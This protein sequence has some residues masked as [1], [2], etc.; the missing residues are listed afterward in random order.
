MAKRIVNGKR[1]E[2]LARWVMHEVTSLA[3][4]G[5]YG[6]LEIKFED[7]CPVHMRKS[8]SLIPPEDLTRENPKK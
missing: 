5:Y 1:K 2:A 3:A 6:R 8:E 7:G 4:K